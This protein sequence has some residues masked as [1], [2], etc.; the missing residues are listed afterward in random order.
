MK[1]PALATAFAF[2]LLISTAHGGT[3]PV[4]IQHGQVW[5]IFRDGVPEM[6]KELTDQV[7]EAPDT[8]Q[9]GDLYDPR[10]GTFSPRPVPQPVVVKDKVDEL[11]DA[12]IAKGVIA[13]EELPDGIKPADADATTVG[14]RVP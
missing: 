2:G 4:L 11:R 6:T 10:S 7:V 3:V 12:L 5:E 9:E 14:K 1:Y 13:A 8:V